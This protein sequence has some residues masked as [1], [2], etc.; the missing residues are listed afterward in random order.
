MCKGY[1]VQTVMGYSS[2]WKKVSVVWT[3]SE[4]RERLKKEEEKEIAAEG[5]IYYI[6]QHPGNQVWDLNI[7]IYF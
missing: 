2:N 5:H 3:Q 4:K 6:L 7:Y 1:E